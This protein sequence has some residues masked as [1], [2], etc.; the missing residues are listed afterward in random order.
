MV[1]PIWEEDFS[2][3]LDSFNMDRNGAPGTFVDRSD[4]YAKVSVGFPG[5]KDP[6]PSAMIDTRL[7][8][9]GSS[10]L[11]PPRVH[12]TS[13]PSGTANNVNCCFV[14]RAPALDRVK[15]SVDCS[16]K[17][18]VLCDVGELWWMC[19]KWIKYPALWL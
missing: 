1:T 4:D 10:F 6:V 7:T 16:S 5:L 9:A 15:S 3:T 13:P 17:K 19:A 18:Y 2:H 8:I 11:Y 14:Q 12:I